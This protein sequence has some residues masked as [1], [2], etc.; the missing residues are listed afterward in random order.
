MN[1]PDGKGAAAHY[2]RNSSKKVLADGSIKEYT[3]LVPKTSNAKAGRPKQSITK[4][5]A[6]DEIKDLNRNELI[7]LMD[8]LHALKLERPK[9]LETPEEEPDTLRDPSALL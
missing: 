4:T 3:Y 6:Y 9:I 1:E 2:R 5:R 7:Q 8:Y